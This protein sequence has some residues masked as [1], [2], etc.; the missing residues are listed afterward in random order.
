MG[1]LSS[2][3]SLHCHLCQQ[4]FFPFSSI[5]FALDAIDNKKPS[6][7]KWNRIDWKSSQLCV[8]W[9]ILQNAKSYV[10]IVIEILIETKSIDHHNSIRIPFWNKFW[11]FIIKCFRL[12]FNLCQNNLNEFIFSFNIISLLTAERFRWNFNKISMQALH[13]GKYKMLILCGKSLKL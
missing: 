6:T 4:L 13:G 11:H 5:V 10:N 2:K 7:M 3:Y 12:Q 9:Q 1:E 8:K